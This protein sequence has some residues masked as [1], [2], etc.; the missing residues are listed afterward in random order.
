M[1]ACAFRCCGGQRGHPMPK[2]SVLGSCK[3]PVKGGGNQILVLY[4]AAGALNS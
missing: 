4:K 1:C 2:A 3:L